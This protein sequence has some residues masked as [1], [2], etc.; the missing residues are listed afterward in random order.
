MTELE[1]DES[2]LFVAIFCKPAQSQCGSIWTQARQ[3][4]NVRASKYVAVMKTELRA[5]I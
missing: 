2:I 5:C 1:L 3:F 4:E